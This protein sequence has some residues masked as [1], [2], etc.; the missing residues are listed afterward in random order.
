MSTLDIKTASRVAGA[1]ADMTAQLADGVQKLANSLATRND[2]LHDLAS[3]ARELADQAQSAAET[4]D[5]LAHSNELADRPDSALSTAERDLVLALLQ[6]LHVA[7]ESSVK[8]YRKAG[9]RL[10]DRAA[11]ARE[12]WLDPTDL[13]RCES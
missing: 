5:Q 10:G 3:V 1:A 8:L 2:E 12:H 6:T 11:V 13:D 9:Q 4:I 7:F